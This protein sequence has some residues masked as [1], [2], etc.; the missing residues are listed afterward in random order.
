[1]RPAA[2]LPSLVG[3]DGNGRATKG[4]FTFMLSGTCVLVAHTFSTFRST[5][6][7]GAH[8]P[9][10]HEI[11]LALIRA[12]ICCIDLWPAKTIPHC[13]HPHCT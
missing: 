11:D 8:D 5:K 10:N 9:D 1:M 7:K 6:G 4:D 2:S 13:H 3:D 12:L